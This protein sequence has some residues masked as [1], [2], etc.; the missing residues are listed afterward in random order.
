MIMQFISFC[1]QQIFLHLVCAEI[2]R[3]WTAKVVIFLNKL[4]AAALNILFIYF[5]KKR[6]V[7]NYV[8]RQ[9]ICCEHTRMNCNI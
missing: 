7:E 2:I 9:P 5:E 1:W 6:P 3:S 4:R 8:N